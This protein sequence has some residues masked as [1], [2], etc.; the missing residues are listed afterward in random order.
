MDVER[1]SPGLILWYGCPAAPVVRAVDHKSV[2]TCLPIE[3]LIY[4]HRDSAKAGQ[5][6]FRLAEKLWDEA[7]TYAPLVPSS[8]V[9]PFVMKSS[10]IIT[11]YHGCDYF[12]IAAIATKIKLLDNKDPSDFSAK[13]KL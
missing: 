9:T 10:K 3:P 7:V 6:W 13:S 12:K 1:S 11:V 4:G 5:D 8:L 2:Q